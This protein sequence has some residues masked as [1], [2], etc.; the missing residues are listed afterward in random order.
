MLLLLLLLKVDFFLLKLF[1]VFVAQNVE[2]LRR[3]KVEVQHLDRVQ[4][5]V[6]QKDAIVFSVDQ[7]LIVDPELVGQVERRRRRVAVPRRRGRRCRRVAA[8]ERVGGRRS[9]PERRDPS[10]GAARGVGEGPAA[11]RSGEG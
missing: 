11:D 9:R 3:I 2:Q 10:S 1:N 6:R 4:V 8:V 5:A 7:V